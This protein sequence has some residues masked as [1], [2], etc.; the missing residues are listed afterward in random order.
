MTCQHGTPAT[1]TFTLFG[2]A[3]DRSVSMYCEFEAPDIERAV[4]D[5]RS[6]ATECALLE[7]WEHSVCV[8]RSRI[9]SPD[10]SLP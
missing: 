7:V 9:D 2:L 4:E 5:A 6:L 8:Y 3:A 10:G 1:R